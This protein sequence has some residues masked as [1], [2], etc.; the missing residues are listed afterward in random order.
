[1]LKQRLRYGLTIGAGFAAGMAFL[2][3]PGLLLLLVAFAAV[4]QWEFYQLAAR[5]GY[6]VHSR[7]GITLG[8][9]WMLTV[10]LLAAPPGKPHPDVPGWEAAMLIA[11]C[12]IVL[13]RT[14]ADAQAR[15][16]FETAAITFLGILYG[17]VMLS[18]YLRLAQ[19]EAPRFWETTRAGVFL[20]FFLSVV[21]K[22]S[23][24]GAYAFGTRWGRHKLFP[25][26][27]PAK[28]W[29]GLAGGLLAGLAVG[30]LT[31]FIAAKCHWGPVGIFWTADGAAAILNPFRTGLIAL[32]LVI[33][34]VLG[35]LIESM[36]KR[37][38]QVK[39]SSGV[40]PGIGG[41]LD[42]VDSLIFAPP[43]LYF[44]LVWLLP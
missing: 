11:I 30:L 26:I 3:G 23:D 24:T 37:A 38:V 13:V 15:R 27:S 35:D 14:M 10:Y 12:F 40:F 41:V 2:P 6:R 28:S 44:A 43:V 33:V 39:D 5:D 31:G 22:L 42:V 36:F 7:L 16:A 34:G 20:C 32:A 17:P 29:E 9:L 4:C 1:M 8:G 21:V 19:W 18:Y 25:R